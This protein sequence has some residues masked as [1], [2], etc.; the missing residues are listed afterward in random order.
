[1]RKANRLSADSG[2]GGSWEA[3]A[4]TLLCVA[5]AKQRV[6]QVELARR[7]SDVSGEVSVASIRN[8]L[9][10]GSFSA[11][12]LLQSLSVIGSHRIDLRDAGAE[13]D[14]SEP[15]KPA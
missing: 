3:A 8:K 14:E 2:R 11:A 13:A 15:T 5:L 6:S 10:R 1:M 9:S 4:K 12:F 7:L